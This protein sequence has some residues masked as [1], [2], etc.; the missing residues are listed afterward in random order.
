MPGTASRSAVVGADTH[1]VTNHHHIHDEPVGCGRYRKLARV[2][3]RRDLD[4]A[5]LWGA[6]RR[7]VLGTATI[8]TMLYVPSDGTLRLWLRPPGAEGPPGPT[9][10][11][12]LD[13]RALLGPGGTE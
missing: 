7:V 2:S 8:Q 12:E 6:L 1:A 3:K 13:L 9:D 5:A 10:G 11:V 4:E